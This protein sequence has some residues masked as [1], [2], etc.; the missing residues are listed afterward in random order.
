MKEGDNVVHVVTRTSTSMPGVPSYSKMEVMSFERD[1]DQ[2]KGLLGG[3]MELQL[4]QLMQ[5]V[6]AS[7]SE[8]Q[9]SPTASKSPAKSKPRK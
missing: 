1:G 5:Q 8:P 6:A 2:W 4:G 9:S 7:T 3:D